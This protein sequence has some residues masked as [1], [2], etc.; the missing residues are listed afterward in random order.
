MP[1][2]VLN[3]SM[4]Y[5]RRLTKQSIFFHKLSSD[6]QNDNF[7][8]FSRGGGGGGLSRKGVLSSLL[9]QPFQKIVYIFS[10]IFLAVTW[11]FV[12]HKFKMV[13]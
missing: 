8:A 10:I 9:Y 2:N 3:S 5:V 12:F 6:H 4:A 1:N 7:E 13:W 11:F